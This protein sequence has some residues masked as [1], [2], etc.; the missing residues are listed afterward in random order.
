MLT[1]K[2]LKELGD[3]FNELETLLSLF[4]ETSGDSLKFEVLKEEA[5]KKAV[6]FVDMIKECESDSNK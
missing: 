3:K 1:N 2:K 5:L 4:D 6:A